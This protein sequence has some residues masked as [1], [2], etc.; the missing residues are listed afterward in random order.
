M[1]THCSESN[2]DEAYQ[3]RL[4]GKNCRLREC[5]R[6][7]GSARDSEFGVESCCFNQTIRSTCRS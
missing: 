2:V 1:L 5:R 4:V 3:Y 6:M 7:S